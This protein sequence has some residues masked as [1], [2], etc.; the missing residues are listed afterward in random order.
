MST[1]GEAVLCI[2]QLIDYGQFRRF[3]TIYL[4][5]EIPDDLCRHLFL[6]FLKRPTSAPASVVVRNTGN[7]CSLILTIIPAGYMKQ[8]TSP[9]FG[10]PGTTQ[11]T[12]WVFLGKLTLK[13]PVKNPEEK[14]RPK[15][16]KF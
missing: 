7:L 5:L 14:T 16:S 3:L 6:S 1:R 2:L 13:N 9:G 10:H 4:E 11:K 12:R 8:A 15:T